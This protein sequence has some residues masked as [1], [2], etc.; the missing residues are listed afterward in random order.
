MSLL[1]I[2]VLFYLYLDQL[3]IKDNM[4]WIKVY[5]DNFPTSLISGCSSAEVVGQKIYVQHSAMEEFTI[6]DPS[7]KSVFL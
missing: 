4:P 2:S 3:K 6:F 5:G 1:L 7:K